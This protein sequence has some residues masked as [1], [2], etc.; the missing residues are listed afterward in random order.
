MLIKQFWTGFIQIGFT[1]TQKGFVPPNK[2]KK[3]VIIRLL[4]Y[5]IMTVGPFNASTEKFVIIVS[6]CGYA[7]V[8]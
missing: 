8:Q 5:C 6:Y 4:P 3:T 1:V 7:V 2:I